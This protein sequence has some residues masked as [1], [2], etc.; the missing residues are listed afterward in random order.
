MLASL[1]RLTFS[2]MAMFMP[3]RHENNYRLRRDVGICKE[4]SRFEDESVESVYFYQFMKKRVEE[5]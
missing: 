1:S 2:E 4:F 5:H 3:V